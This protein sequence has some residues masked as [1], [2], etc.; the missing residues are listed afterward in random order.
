[1]VQANINTF[2]RMDTTELSRPHEICRH[3]M[4]E[5]R[6]EFQADQRPMFHCDCSKSRRAYFEY[7]LECI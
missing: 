7:S 1:M 5:L 2:D 6:G 3:M 4:R